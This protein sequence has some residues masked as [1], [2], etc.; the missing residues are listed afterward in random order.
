MPNDTQEPKRKKSSLL[1][2][3]VIILLLLVIFLLWWFIFRDKDT[4]NSNTNSTNNTT[5]NT[6]VNTNA[7]VTN[8]NTNGTTAEVSLNI[9]AT[10]TFTSAPTNWFEEVWFQPKS[11]GG[12][13][14]YGAN[15]V[16]FT[17]IE[18]NS[19]SGIMTNVEQDVSAY[20]HL[21]LHMIAT[22]NQQTLTGTGWNGR[23]APVA[24]VISY[25]DANGVEH[26]SLG[27]DPTAAGQ[28]FWRGFYTLD[29]NSQAKATNG[30]KVTTGQKYT[31]DFDLMTL[32]PKP[33]K[34]HYVAIE[35]AG[36]KPRAGTV[37][38]LSLVATD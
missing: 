3:F 33:A 10:L 11:S 35:G 15:G 36:W 30:V 38:E 32:N 34:I 16:T 7:V 2:I 1:V 28:M 22:N 18:S 5:V 14:T 24:V 4:T 13:V 27:E 29:P 37:H 25:L 9:V 20:S 26:K 19:R 21:N 12:E 17:G 23:E 31:Y 8:T 6:N